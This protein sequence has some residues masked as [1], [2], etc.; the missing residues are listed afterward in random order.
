[1]APSCLFWF[2]WWER[3]RRIFDWEELNDHKLKEAFIRSLMEWSRTLLG[4]DC[5][6]L[7]DFIDS[8]NCGWWSLVVFV[9]A[10]TLFCL[11]GSSC[12]PP[13]L[14]APPFFLLVLFNISFLCPSKKR[15]KN[16]SINKGCLEK[17]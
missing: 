17:F 14:G 16:Y 9:F 2:V 6:S 4:R 1:M 11:G 5:A 13:C 15:K 8:L 10:A 3:N 7:L 12:I